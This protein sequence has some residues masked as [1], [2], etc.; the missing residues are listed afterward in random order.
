MVR[1]GVRDAYNGRPKLSP[2]HVQ[3][4]SGR[5]IA[6]IDTLSARWGVEAHTRGKTVWAELPL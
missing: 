6:M 2:V 4:N 1:I 3:N 5:G